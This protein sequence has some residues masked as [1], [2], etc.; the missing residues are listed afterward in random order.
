MEQV[1]LSLAKPITQEILHPLQVSTGQPIRFRHGNSLLP[2]LRD[3]LR[4]L[5]EAARSR[6]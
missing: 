6:M 2:G 5:D 1:L 4:A 3:A